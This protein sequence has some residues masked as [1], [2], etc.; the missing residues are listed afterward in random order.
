MNKLLKLA[1]F[2]S[3]NNSSMISAYSINK[4]TPPKKL[5]QKGS[6]WNIAILNGGEITEEF[7]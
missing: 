6:R 2:A 4:T 7:Q 1:D 3:F 5:P